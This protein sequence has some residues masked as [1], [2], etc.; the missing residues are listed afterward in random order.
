MVFSKA[1]GMGE[2][3][4]ACQSHTQHIQAG[5]GPFTTQVHL[6]FM[7]VTYRNRGEGLLTGAEMTPRWLVAS[8]RLP[9]VG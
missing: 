5:Q 8:S 3:G 2:K 4:K 9:Q 1:E 6:G 7:G